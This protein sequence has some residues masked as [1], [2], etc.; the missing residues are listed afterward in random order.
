MSYPDV[1]GGVKHGLAVKAFPS[2]EVLSIGEELLIGKIANTNAQFLSRKVT[3]LGGRVIRVV[4]V[5]DDVQTIADTLKE[6]LNRKSTLILTTGG[7]GPTFDDKTLE[8]IAVGLEKPLVLDAEAF[9]Q[10]KEKYEKLSAARGQVLELTPARVKMAKL[11]EGAEALSNPVGTAPGVLL[12]SEETVI[13]ALPGVPSEMEA[14]FEESVA[15]L[16]R[17]LSKNVFYEESLRLERVYESDLAPM[18]D[19]VMRGNPWVYMKSHP[20]REEGKAHIELHLTTSAE[21]M[22]TAKERVAQSVKEISG[23]VVNFGGIVIRL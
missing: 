2:V 23:L 17:K 16:I 4:T 8:G 10:V 3:S 6:A 1:E 13:I 11:P 9:K 18:I 15:P 20:R 22:E 14:I 5:G 12:R 21:N 19:K 7:L